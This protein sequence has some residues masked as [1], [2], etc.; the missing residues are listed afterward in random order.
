MTS[1]AQQDEVAANSHFGK[2]WHNTDFLKLWAA[3]SISLMGTQLTSLAL[4][5]IAALT[6]DP[7][8]LQMGLLTAAAQAPF[9]L[10]SLPAGVWADRMRRR[11]I[12][13]ATDLV[14]AV[15]LLSIPLMAATGQLQLPQLYVVIFGIGAFSVLSQIAHRS[16]VPSLVGHAQLVD[17]NSKLQI[18]YSAA[19]SAGPGLGGLLIQLVSAPLAV[20]L[21]AVSFLVSAFLLG[22]IDK[23]EPTPL[24]PVQGES[25]VHEVSVG[26]RTLFGHFL[27]R[28]IVWTQTTA[29]VC[30]SA[31]VALYVL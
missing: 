8:P 26:L 27:L 23:S 17:A 15:L 25:F 31:T 16:Y 20:L 12:L 21:D 14:S 19:D 6:L 7:S 30:K 2:L 28:P 4:P 29:S 3:Q 5:L 24:R 22:T 9:L 1:P 11:P 10:V 13:I 18:S